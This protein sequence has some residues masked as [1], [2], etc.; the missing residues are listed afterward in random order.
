M[1]GW[2]RHALGR[3]DFSLTHEY[4]A[5]MLGVRRASITDIA[6]EFSQRGLVRYSRARVR[7]IDVRGLSR[8]ACECYRMV[9]D[10][11]ERMLSAPRK[12]GASSPR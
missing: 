3:H 7:I 11:A 10:E 9:S 2:G 4:L 8:A 6:A 12:R 5:E 1:R